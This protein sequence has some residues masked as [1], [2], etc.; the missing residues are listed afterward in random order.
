MTLRVEHEYGES[1][2]QQPR[3]VNLELAGITLHLITSIDADD[4][5][6]LILLNA[7]R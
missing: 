4:L 6:L 1:P 3:P 5:F 2:V 7:H